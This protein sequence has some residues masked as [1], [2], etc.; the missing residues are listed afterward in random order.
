MRIIFAGTPDFASQALSALLA[1]K[2]HEIVL[3]LTQPDRPAGRGMKLTRSAVKEVALTHQLPI[4]QPT[5]LKTDTAQQALIDA[6]A[7]LMI[8]AAYG[9]ILPQKVLDIPLY[10]CLNIHASL[11]PRWRGAAPIQ[12]AILAGDKQTGIT[13]M[14]MDAGLDTGDIL[15]THTVPISETDTAGSLH[16]KLASCGAKAIIAALDALTLLQ[17]RRRKQPMEGVTYAEK[18]KKEEARID[19][20]LPASVLA[21]QIRAFNP[22]PGSYALYNIEPIKFWQAVPIDGHGQP[23]EVL[24]TH[25][26]AI[27]I[28][29]QSGALTVTRLQKPGSRQMDAASFLA[30]FPVK[31]GNFFS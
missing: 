30:G 6:K 1:Q 14:Q 24:D 9:L 5:T 29:C 26:G 13:I 27:T 10:G 23:G 7:D 11:L 17:E 22:F 3:V 12:R 28:A 15:L 8:V 20:S 18:L 2:K 19:W 4:Y 25:K 31:I 21:R 16:D